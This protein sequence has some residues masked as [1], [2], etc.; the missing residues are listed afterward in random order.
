MSRFYIYETD[1]G[2]LLSNNTISYSKDLP[3]ER[4]EVELTP[5][6]RFHTVWNPVTLTLDDNGGG[7]PPTKEELYADFKARVKEVYDDAGDQAEV[8]SKNERILDIIA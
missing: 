6:T 2:K 3:P 4:S 5:A 8:I 7:T 1:T